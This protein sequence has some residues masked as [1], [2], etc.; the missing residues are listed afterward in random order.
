M[1]K[2]VYQLRLWFLFSWDRIVGEQFVLKDINQNRDLMKQLA[3][4]A[5]RV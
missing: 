1:S 4:V 2:H 5:R 3:D